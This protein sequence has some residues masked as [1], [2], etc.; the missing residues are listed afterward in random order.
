M[1]YFSIRFGISTDE[2][3]LKTRIR[4]NY[5]EALFLIGIKLHQ[6]LNKKTLAEK[7]NDVIEYVYL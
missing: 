2:I 7:L 5:T 6:V 3:D 1:S 4:T